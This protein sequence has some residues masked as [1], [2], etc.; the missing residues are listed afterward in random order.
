MNDV[1]ASISSLSREEI[2]KKVR[3]GYQDPAF[4]RKE[5]EDPVVH[6]VMKED[7]IENI[8]ENMTNN[9]F[10]VHD[11]NEADLYNTINEIT[12]SHNAKSMVY[13]KDLGLDLEK[14]TAS[15]QLCF[16]RQIED[17]RKLVFHTDFSI[18]NAFAG[19]A[20]H[21]AACVTSTENQ[22]R[23][24]SLVPPLCIILLKK[25]RVVKSLSEALK[26]V[27]SEFDVLPT[28][29]LFIAGPSRTADV[30]LVTV[31]GVHGSTSVHLILY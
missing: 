31:F 3:A 11:V 22:P 6:I 16:D 5:T 28:N 17:I 1:I 9:K 21:G 23:M 7:L 8:K 30:E 2:L 27:K 18:I 26:K 15:S 4:C 24:L 12:A 14:I 29:V 13:P 19:V 25:E 10:V 20:S